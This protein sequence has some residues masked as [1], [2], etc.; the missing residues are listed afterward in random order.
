MV[1]GVEEVRTGARAQY[2]RL[3]EALVF[4]QAHLSPEDEQGCPRDRR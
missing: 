3:E 1:Y 2:E 4:I